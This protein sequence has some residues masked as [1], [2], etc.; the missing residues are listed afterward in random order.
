VV[1]KAAGILRYL[2]KTKTNVAALSRLCLLFSLIAIINIPQELGSRNLAQLY[3][4]HTLTHSLTH[5]PTTR[6][7][8]YV[9]YD[10]AETVRNSEAV[11]VKFNTLSQYLSPNL[12]QNENT[13]LILLPLTP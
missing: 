1:K 2:C 11:Y 12:F 7:E 9:L 8:I 6:Y 4:T 3:L 10:D 13:L 5:I